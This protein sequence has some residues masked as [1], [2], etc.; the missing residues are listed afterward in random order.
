MKVPT[1]VERYQSEIVRVI[2]VLDGV[3]ATKPQGARWLV[4]GRCTVADLAFLQWTH[5]MYQFNDM[6]EGFDMAQECPA[7]FA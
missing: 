3:L 6:P 7:T 5:A 4:A 2:R 1:A